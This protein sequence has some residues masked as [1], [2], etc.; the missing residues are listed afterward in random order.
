MNN[1]KGK[2]SKEWT[3]IIHTHRQHSDS[4]EYVP[5]LKIIKLIQLFFILSTIIQ[6]M[7]PQHV[8]TATW[9]LSWKG[10]E[11]ET[12]VLSWDLKDNKDEEMQIF[13]G[14][15]FQRCGAWHW[16]DHAISTFQNNTRERSYERKNE[17]LKNN[18]FYSEM[19]WQFGLQDL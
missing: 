3:S 2:K 18:A 17:E 19:E 13:H 8:Y 4:P 6:L 9:I 16:N 11:E 12:Y 7:L 1:K 5:T 15:E 14:S 10:T